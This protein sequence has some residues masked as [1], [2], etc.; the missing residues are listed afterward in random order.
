M[1]TAQLEQQLKQ[2]REEERQAFGRLVFIQGRI[3]QVMEILGRNDVDQEKPAPDGDRG[4][5]A[6]SAL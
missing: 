4:E 3:A 1:D 5:S 2:L 6:E